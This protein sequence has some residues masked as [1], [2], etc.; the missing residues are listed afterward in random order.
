MFENL[1]PEILKDE[2]IMQKQGDDLIALDMRR[3]EKDNITVLLI[4]TYKEKI[5]IYTRREK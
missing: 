1:N 5:P 3:N 4:K 2:M